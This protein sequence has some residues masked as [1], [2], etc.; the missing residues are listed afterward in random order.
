MIHTTV[1][2]QI[3]FE[4]L[5]ESISRLGLEEKRQIESILEQQIEQAEEDLWDRDP[6][7]QAEIREARVD[8]AAGNYVTLD[9]Y[10]QH[11]HEAA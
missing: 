6:I 10:L 9:E 4:S 11:P 3:P 2:M 5:I 1:Q 7:V 8:Y